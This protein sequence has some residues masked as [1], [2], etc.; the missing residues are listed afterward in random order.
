MKSIISCIEPLSFPFRTLDPFLFCV[1]HKDEYP[2]GD[3]KMQ[4][5]RKGNGADFNPT[6]PY[7][8]YHGDRIPGFPQVFTFT[9]T[10]CLQPGVS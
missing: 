10:F 3:E 9:A 1:Y 4:A 5:P 6:A 7:R 2:A 8:M